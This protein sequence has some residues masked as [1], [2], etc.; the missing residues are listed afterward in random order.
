MK[1]EA[2]PFGSVVTGS[3]QFQNMENQK[4]ENFKSENATSH[5]FRDSAKTSLGIAESE[6]C[7]RVHKSH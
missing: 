7:Y 2:F 1:S 6:I 4:I 3:Y 5:G